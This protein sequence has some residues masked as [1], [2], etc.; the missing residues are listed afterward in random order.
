MQEQIFLNIVT[1][2]GLLA[3]GT[4]YIPEYIRR[5]ASVNSFKVL[6]KTFLGISEF[7][8]VLNFMSLFTY[9]YFQY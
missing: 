6:A 3:H 9:H 8:S 1:S 5:A 7:F 2:T 4:E